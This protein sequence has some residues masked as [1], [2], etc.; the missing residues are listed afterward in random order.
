MCEVILHTRA[1]IHFWFALRPQ[2]TVPNCN[3][4]FPLSTFLWMF[5][6]CVY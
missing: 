5:M 6:C 1:C 2:S 3:I 4:F